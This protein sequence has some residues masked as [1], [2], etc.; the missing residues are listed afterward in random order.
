MLLLKQLSKKR[1][2]EKEAERNKERDRHADRLNGAQTNICHHLCACHEGLMQFWKFYPI[3]QMLELKRRINP[4]ILHSVFPFVITCYFLI[5]FQIHLTP[6]IISVFSYQFATFPS[7]FNQ[8]NISMWKYSTIMTDDILWGRREIH[9]GDLS[10]IKNKTVVVYSNC[11]WHHL[12]FMGHF[13]HHMLTTKLNWQRSATG[14][15]SLEAW[16]LQSFTIRLEKA[17]RL[18]W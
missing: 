5:K 11:D 16:E 4:E 7:K 9:L 14:D 3:C 1:Q 10:L 17:L 12:M 6:L 13:M 18:L 8:F 15:D 2:R